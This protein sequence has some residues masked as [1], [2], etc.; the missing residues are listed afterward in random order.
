MSLTIHSV[1]WQQRQQ[2]LAAIRRKVFI[3][4]QGV[5]ESEEWDESDAAENT[6]HMLVTL[7]SEAVANARVIQ[8]ANGSKIGR[9][10]V[11]AKHRKKGVGLELLKGLLQ[12]VLLRIYTGQASQ[13]IY[14][15]AQTSAIGFYTRLAFE[16][17]GE[18]FD[19]A[20]IDHRK[21]LFDSNQRECLTALYQDQVLRLN[22]QR[23]FAQ[24]IFQ[25][26][27][28]S[29]QNILIL[30]QNL[31]AKLFN[32]QVVE[33]L[34]AFARYNRR[35]KIRILIFDSSHLASINAPLLYLTQRLPSSIE[36]RTLNEQVPNDEHA[37]VIYDAK[38]LVYFNDEENTQGFANYLA[39]GEAKRLVN[40]FTRWWDY[41]SDVDPEHR[42]LHL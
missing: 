9:M 14:L 40:E 15:H 4:E 1:T 20:G 27:S 26:C 42:E 5:P 17:Q 39:A 34:S 11:L 13:T 32:A 24:H 19:E 38:H 41:E 6:L 37:Y 12:E 31:S 8:T 10:C 36:I 2:T 33:K 7:D 23:E 21:M 30:S 22:H 3:D 16:A 25:M 28:I 29:R 18:L 35:A